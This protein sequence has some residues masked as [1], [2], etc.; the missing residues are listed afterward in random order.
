MLRR[1][2]S[3]RILFALVLLGFLLG[4]TSDPE[5]ARKCEYVYV[6]NRGENTVSVVDGVN[7]NPVATIP[8]GQEPSGVAISPSRDEIYVINSRSN[9]VSVIDA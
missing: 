3:A 2:E 4:C 9:T 5:A 1:A 8:V 7:L 6:S